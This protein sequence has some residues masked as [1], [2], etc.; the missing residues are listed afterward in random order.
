MEASSAWRV[1]ERWP[2]DL[3]GVAA[4]TRILAVNGDPLHPWRVAEEMAAAIPGA[5]LVARVA[6]LSPEAIARQWIRELET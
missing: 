5:R 1:V 3:S 2:A 4:P 6:S